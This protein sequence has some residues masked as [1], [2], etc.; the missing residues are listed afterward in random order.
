MTSL[1]VGA[2]LVAAGP[3]PNP[4]ERKKLQSQDF[5][6][7]QSSS[8]YIASNKFGPKLFQKSVYVDGQEYI[9][10]AKYTMI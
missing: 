9:T 10:L 8:T 3:S 6:A 5:R 4:L 2:A 1:T 7:P